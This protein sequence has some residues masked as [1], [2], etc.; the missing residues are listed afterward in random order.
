MKPTSSSSVA[1]TAAPFIC[2]EPALTGGWALHIY[3]GGAFAIKEENSIIHGYFSWFT[4]LKAAI[5]FS[6]ADS[7]AARADSW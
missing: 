4:G 6:H 3:Q 1:S 5:F 7:S 2:T